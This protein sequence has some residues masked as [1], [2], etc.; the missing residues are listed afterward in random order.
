LAVSRSA[1]T[2]CYII[3]C[4]RDSKYVYEGVATSS[5]GFSFVAVKDGEVIGFISCAESMG[6]IYK[7]ILKEHFFK[8]VFMILPKMFRFCNIKNAI[9]TLLY[10][11][12]SGNGLSSV[13]IL[14]IVVNEGA[15]NKG[16]GQI[17]GSHF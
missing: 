6:S 4:V 12:R 7:Y 3:H 2:I 14:A 8:L 5:T 13:E 16:I 10:P 1:G 17:L 11:S 15:R 9:E